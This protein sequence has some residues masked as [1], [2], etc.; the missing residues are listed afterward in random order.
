MGLGHMIGTIEVGK[1]A[2]LIVLEKNLFEV[3]PDRLSA[4]KVLSTWFEGRLVHGE[5]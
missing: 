5:G 3:E 1:S 4:T 2:D